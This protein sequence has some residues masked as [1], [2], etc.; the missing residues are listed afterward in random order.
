MGELALEQV[1]T[2]KVDKVLH[3]EVR[4]ALMAVLAAREREKFTDIQERF[5]LTSGNLSSHLSQLEQAGYV[6]VKK[7]FLGKKPQTLIEATPKGTKA[8][9]DY[10]ADMKAR[11]EIAATAVAR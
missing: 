11:L 5:H 9:N 2:S 7:T 4:F 8:L 1:P 6:K 3:D 10:I